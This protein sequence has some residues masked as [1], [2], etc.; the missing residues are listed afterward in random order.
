[1]N[2]N[3]LYHLITSNTKGFLIVFLVLR[4]SVGL[5]HAQSEEVLKEHQ[6]RKQVVEEYFLSEGLTKPVVEQREMYDTL[7]RLVEVQEYTKEGDLDDWER[8]RY[9]RNGD[10]IEESELDANG[11]QKKRKVYIYRDRLLIRKEYY[12]HKDRLYKKKEYVYEYHGED[13]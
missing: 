4:T 9:D 2:Q 5:V 7:G 1:M 12:D 3:R 10:M 13:L 11:E 8:Y 6:V